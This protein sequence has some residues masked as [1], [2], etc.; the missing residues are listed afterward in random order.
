MLAFDVDAAPTTT[1]TVTSTGTA[2]TIFTN[3]LA[4]G[5]DHS[6]S[7]AAGDAHTF[8]VFTV[9]ANPVKSDFTSSSGIPLPNTCAP[10]I[11]CI[12][13]GDIHVDLG[14]TTPAF[15]TGVVSADGL[16]RV[17]T[18]CSLNFLDP[19]APDCNP[20][21]GD[22]FWTVLNPQFFTL[23]DSSSFAVFFHGGDIT[24]D[25]TCRRITIGGI[26]ICIPGMGTDPAT[27]SITV[28]ATVTALTVA[29]VDQATAIPEPASRPASDALIACLPAPYEKAGK[30][31]SRGL[32]YLELLQRRARRWRW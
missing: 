17:T 2:T 29:G 21:T 27:E 28:T 30:A 15:G 24:D 19:S 23:P 4:A 20:V 6:F 13:G 26:T 5:L 25:V 3:T 10:S 22:L 7:L 12:W 16:V 18:D 14:F 1:V 31:I 8:D 9:T 11:P 32:C